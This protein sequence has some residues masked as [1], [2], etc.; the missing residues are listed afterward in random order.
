MKDILFIVSGGCITQVE[1]A[2]GVYQAL[3]ELGIIPAQ[4]SGITARGTSAGAAV[5]TCL[6]AS[7]WNPANVI[8]KLKTFVADGN[9]LVSRKWFWMLRMFFGDRCI[10]NRRGLET[11]LRDIVGDRSFPCVTNI[12]TR[13][14]E[15]T[16]LEL[17][18]S[19]ESAL[20][21]TSI[22]RI[23]PKTVIEGKQYVDG[24]YVDN[25]PIEPFMLSLYKHIV[26]ILPPRDL[27]ADKRPTTFIDKLYRGL[28]VKLGQEVTETE[29]IYSQRDKYPQCTVIRPT[30]FDNHPLCLS[31]DFALMKHA[32]Q[33]T[34]DNPDVRDLRNTILT[35]AKARIRDAKL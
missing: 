28:D 33:Y 35:E 31:E 1:S 34:L 22:Q 21:S 2:L 27:G 12:V 9:R 23:F 30:P 4:T 5:N 19:Y 3:G 26:I 16:R 15:F 14:P 24:G 20:A 13:W 7:R 25:V 10:Y 8:D 17:A 32:Y 29:F 18:G 6:A 11:L